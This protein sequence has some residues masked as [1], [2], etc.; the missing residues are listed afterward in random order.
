V[1]KRRSLTRLTN[2]FEGNRL[3]ISKNE[4]LS[5][6]EILRD[7]KFIL[8]QGILEGINDSKII[9]KIKKPQKGRKY[10]EKD[11]RLQTI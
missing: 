6:E 5:E 8:D 3:P 1:W 9:L 4:K 10:N 7:A 2:P 11:T